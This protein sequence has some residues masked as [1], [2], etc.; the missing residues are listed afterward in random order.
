MT[1]ALTAG[2]LD[3]NTLVATLGLLGLLGAVFLETGLL[4]GF[5]LPGD[6]L[7]FTAGVLVAQAEPFVPLWAI[8]LS[9][10]VAAVLGDQCGY[11]IGRAAGPAIFERPGAKRL[12][13]AQLARAQ[14]FFDKYG[15]RT[16]VLA[17]FVPVVRTIAPVMAGASGMKY[18]TFLTYNIIGGIAWGVVVPVLGYLLG[19]I[20]FVRSHIEVI[21]IGIVALSILP[22]AVNYARA[23]TNKGADT[24]I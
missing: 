11:L 12:G 13:P 17:R 10:P 3:P 7:L 18:R 2:L 5:F 4:V 23:R 1:S 22:I 6:S 24:A 16:V 21:L 15:A 9:V 8:L 14:E 19:G 20:P